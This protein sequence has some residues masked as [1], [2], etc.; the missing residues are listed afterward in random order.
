MPVSES[1]KKANA[2]WDSENMAT[3]ACKIKKSQAEKFKS[4][5]SSIGKTSNAVIRDYVLV[6]PGLITEVTALG[7]GGAVTSCY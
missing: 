4:Y 3:V 1:K 6:S 5:C 2:K 7:L